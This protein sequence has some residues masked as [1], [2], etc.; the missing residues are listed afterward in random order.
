LPSDLRGK[1][2][3]A[4]LVQE[5]LL[6]AHRGFAGFNGTDA[7]DLRVW[8]CGILK[9]N[10]TDC[11]RRFRESSKRSIGRELSLEAAHDAGGP[12]D[13]E[14]DPDPTPCTQSIARESVAALREALLRLPADEQAVICLRQFESL[15]FQE[16]GRRLGRS[17]EATRKLFSRAIARLQ[18][19][20]EVTHGAGR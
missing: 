17:P 18:R 12:G 15:A 1:C 20:L 14:V 2:D 7:D 9:H 6:D 19:L 8:L 3:D 16:I 10:L 11:I 4:D 13:G 5:T